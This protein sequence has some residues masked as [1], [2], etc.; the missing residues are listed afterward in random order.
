MI[1]FSSLGFLFKRFA[2]VIYP[3]AAKDDLTWVL[4][5][6][7]AGSLILDAGGGTAVLSEFARE[8]R[9][10][11]KLVALD[12]ASGMLKYT[13]DYV[14]PVK[15]VAEMLPFKDGTFGAVLIGDAF[16]HFRDQGQALREV[17]RVL[18]PDGVL[19]VF[20][21]DPEKPMG[22]AIQGAEKMLRE[23]SRFYAPKDLALL[24]REA[25]FIPRIRSYDWRYAIEA[26][27]AD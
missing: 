19:F 27:R 5:W 6:L 18:Q 13:E 20:E 17:R 15:G 14:S 21:I 10:D 24:L 11:L 3:K 23:C 12:P 8:V 7:K 26:H 9:Q 22:K 1:P 2:Q 16:H 4:G 25:G